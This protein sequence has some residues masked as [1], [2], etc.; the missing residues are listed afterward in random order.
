MAVLVTGSA[1]FIGSHL[2]ESLLGSEEVVGVDCY[3][4]FYPRAVKER[5]ASKARDHREFTEAQVDLCDREALN[6]LPD[7]VDAVIHLAARV[8]VRP[9][10][11]DP[12]LYT[13]VNVMG[14][15]NLL[16]WARS[17][18]IR[19]F[20][21]ASSSSVYGNRST[22]PFS[23]EDRVDAPISPYAATKRAGELVCHTYHHLF[24]MSIVALRFFTVYGPRQRP[25]L[26]IHKFARLLRSGRPIPMF[27]DGTTERD[28]T[29]IEDIL[30]GLH[31]GLRYVRGSGSPAFE[32]VNLG[33]STT[34]ALKRMIQTL[35][36]QMGVEPVI[37]QQAEQAGDV[38]RTFADITKAAR[39][40]GYRPTTDF[41]DGVARFLRWFDRQPDHP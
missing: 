5:N 9:S 34:V 40:F 20:V 35:A 1:G 17:R 14:T 36:A 28:Y 30:Q 25:D 3:D 6:A 33:E 4:D 26:A 32:I 12:E 15:V 7:T 39:L 16:D 13:G 24:G 18:G 27:G 10:I 11:G 22:V 41:D 2:V 31:G 29:F 38:Q 19:N 8:G 23:E 37:D 21:F